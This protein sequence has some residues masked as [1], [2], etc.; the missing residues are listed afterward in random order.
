MKFRHRLR[1]LL[2]KGKLESEMA[3]EMRHHV[4]LQTELNLKA[5]MSADEARYSAQR[6]FGNIA[7]IQEQAREQRG[8]VWLEGFAKDLRHAVRALRKS[9]G[10]TTTALLTLALGIGAS[11]ALFSVVNSVLLRPLPFPSA[12]RLTVVWETNA[13]QEAELVQ[14]ARANRTRSL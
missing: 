4:E 7:S 6:E 10:F 8:W 1:G 13:Q 3:E 11:T 14:P 12:D 2:L 5:G 9:P